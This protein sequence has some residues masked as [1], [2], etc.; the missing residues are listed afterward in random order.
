[1]AC[2]GEKLAVRVRPVV[3]AR[4]ARPRPV[5]VLLVI[6]ACGLAFGL[7]WL[8]AGEVAR[9]RSSEVRRALAQARIDGA[10]E[11]GQR[12]ALERRVLALEERSRID[13]SAYRELEAARRSAEARVVRLRQRLAVY[14]EVIA[15][16]HRRAPLVVRSVAVDREPVTD[17]SYRY[18]LELGRWPEGGSV[19]EGTLTAVVEGEG[20]GDT[21]NASSGA[22]GRPLAMGEPA[23][24]RLRYRTRLEGRLRVPEEAGSP[25]TL[26]LEV[27]DRDGEL[28]LVRRYPWGSVLGA[29]ADG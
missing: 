28:V 3:L 29:P 22:P 6:L 13:A 23:P 21:G 14:Q 10:R 18:V 2:L 17:G 4:P 11:R 26:T 1:M 7:G 5:P 19:Y 27:R 8:T 16:G 15:E 24:F 12:L 20:R 9:Q 25:R